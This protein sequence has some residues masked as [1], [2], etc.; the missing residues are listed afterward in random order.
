MKMGEK[1]TFVNFI[2]RITDGWVKIIFRHGVMGMWWVGPGKCMRSLCHDRI[3]KRL[4]DCRR[5]GGVLSFLLSITHSFVRKIFSK[6]IHNVACVY[7]I[8]ICA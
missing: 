1:L 5:L 8:R 2:K 7:A 3:G 4:L 6:Y